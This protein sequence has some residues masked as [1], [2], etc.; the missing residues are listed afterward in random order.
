MKSNQQIT[1]SHGEWVL[2]D[3]VQAS[4]FIQKFSVPGT[5]NAY[6]DGTFDELAHLVKANMHDFEPGT[7]SVNNDVILVNIPAD[8]VKTTVV[9]ITPENK[10]RVI[11]ESYVRQEGEKPVTRKVMLG[12]PVPAKYAQVV[13][14]RADVLAQDNARSTDAE[15]EMIAV[16]GKL[17]AVEP[18]HPETMLRNSQHDEGGTY[19]EYTEQEWQNAY[20]YWDNHAYLVESLQEE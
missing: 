19:R 7:G 13:L 14:Y 4:E 2:K 15:W 16:L 20:E 18:M 5:G 1:K 17:D 11:E 8:K 10:H 12:Q 6:F 9:R 3:E